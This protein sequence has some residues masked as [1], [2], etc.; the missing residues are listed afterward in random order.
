MSRPIPWYHV[1]G[2]AFSDLAAAIQYAGMFRGWQ[3]IIITWT[4]A[5]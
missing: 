5:R 3:A 2:V 4:E 1:R